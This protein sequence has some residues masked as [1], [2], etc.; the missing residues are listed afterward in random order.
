M[1]KK[2]VRNCCQFFY[3]TIL[4]K[5]LFTIKFVGNTYKFYNFIGN[6]YPRNELPT[7]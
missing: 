3:K 4:Y 6:N 1:K 2:I 5:T 7:N